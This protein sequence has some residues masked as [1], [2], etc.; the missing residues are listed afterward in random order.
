MEPEKVSLKCN[1]TEGE[2]VSGGEECDGKEITPAR[3]LAAAVAVAGVSLFFMIPVFSMP[4][5][6]SIF[7][8]PG[9]LPFLTGL[10]LLLMA[11]GLGVRSIRAGGAK[12]FLHAPGSSARNYFADIE[13]QRTLLVIGIIIVY[14]VLVDLVTFDLRLP[15]GFFVFRFSGYELFSIL[16]LTLILRIFWRATLIRCTLVSASW[17]IALVSVF[18]YAFH[19]LMPGLG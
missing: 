9:L 6:D 17:I 14:V 7:T 1:D 3:D 12:G 15:A 5:P 19:I 2:M 16:T 10:T 18:R 13:N 11:I 8:H 4:N